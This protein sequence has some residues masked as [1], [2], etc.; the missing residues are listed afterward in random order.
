M[1]PISPAILCSKHYAPVP[2]NPATILID[3]VHIGQLVANIRSLVR[4]MLSAIACIVGIAL[5]ANSPTLTR[6]EEIYTPQRVV[7]NSF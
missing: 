2:D 1:L 3:K 5:V 7:T 4:P 6:I